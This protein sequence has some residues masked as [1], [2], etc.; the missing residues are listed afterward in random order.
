[1]DIEKYISLVGVYGP[2]ILNI[3]SIILLWNRQII[4]WSYILGSISSIIINLVL[5]TMIKDPRPELDTKLEKLEKLE[6]DNSKFLKANIYGMPSGHSQSVGFSCTFIYYA[7]HNF[8][9][10]LTYFAISL[11]TMMQRFKYKEHTIPQI[12]IGFIIGIALAHTTFFI[13]KQFLVKELQEKK[14]D[15]CII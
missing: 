5:K 6:K 1:M 9:Y 13:Y 14:D 3:I 15:E 4:M 8:N 7:L 10:F 11:V 2:I 12:I